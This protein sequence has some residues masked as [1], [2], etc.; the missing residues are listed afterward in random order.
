MKRIFFI[1]LILGLSGLQCCDRRTD[2][3]VYIDDALDLLYTDSEGNNLIDNGTMNPDNFKIYYMVDGVKTLFSLEWQYDNPKGYAVI[4]DELGY[5][6][7]IVMFLAPISPVILFELGENE[8][9]T[10]TFENY[11]VHNGDI[12]FSKVIYNGKVVYDINDE[13]LKQQYEENHYR[14]RIVK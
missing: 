6:S 5:G 3:C 4:P 2:C 14:I 9:D 11:E 10:I 7:S 13:E 8:T 1:L 12:R